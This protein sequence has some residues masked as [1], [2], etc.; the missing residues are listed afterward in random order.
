M[1]GPAGAVVGTCDLSKARFR[2]EVR[3]DTTTSESFVDLPRGS[4]RFTTRAPGCVIVTFSAVSTS[5]RG[6]I[7]IRSLLDGATI[8]TPD[9][10][11]WSVDENR[12]DELRSVGVRS[13]QF[14]YKS[15][16]AGPHTIAIQWWSP[17][18]EEISLHQ[19]T[20]VVQYRG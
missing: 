18:G 10:V 15:V 12:D 17:G 8:A 11:V 3:T 1:L 7:V 5:V 16:A 6:S 14:I 2:T 20:L 13:F 19:R 9:L 4:V